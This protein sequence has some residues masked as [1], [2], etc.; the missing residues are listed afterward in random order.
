MAKTHNLGFPRIGAQRE[1]K[2]GVESYW[3]GQSS[4]TDLDSLARD[5]RN[6]HW[7]HQQKL[8]LVPVGDFA[9]YDQVLD[10]SVMVGAIP[11]IYGWKGGKVSLTTYFT[12]ARG[13]HKGTH[14]HACAHGHHEH[15]SSQGAPA[16]EMKGSKAP[17]ARNVKPWA[18]G[19]GR[20]GLMN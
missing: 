18:N 4:L 20:Q 11:E 10:T 5:L 3:K 6:R 2:F 15:S 14:D 17:K 1:L 19:P 8:D 9:F 13:A 16:Q 12:M 7:Q